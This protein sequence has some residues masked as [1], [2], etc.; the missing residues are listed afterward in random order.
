MTTTAATTIAKAKIKLLLVT[1]ILFSACDTTLYHEFRSVYYGWSRSD[2]LLFQFNNEAAR[3]LEY[4]NTQIELRCTPNYP[5]KELWL[6][7]EGGSPIQADTLK[8][9]IF[10]DY[11]RQNGTTAGLM[12]Q[13][14]IPYK[15][16]KISSSDTITTVRIVH[17]MKD[18]TIRGISDVGIRL[19]HPDRHP[20]LKN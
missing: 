14:S 2:T 16:I 19:S 3:D 8:C 10:N 15:N 5:Y 13:L 20:P 9:N 17:I 4:C 18:D 11:G 7:I 12:Y 1:A 6:R